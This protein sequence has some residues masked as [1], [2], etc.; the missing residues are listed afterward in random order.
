MKY[1]VEVTQIG[2]MVEQLS[3]HNMIILFNADAPKDLVEISVL[4]TVD[5]LREDVE[6]GDTMNIGNIKYKITGVG[7]AVNKNLKELGHCT[8]V[9]NGS[10]EPHLPGVINLEGEIPKIKKGD[11]ISIY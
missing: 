2:E 10:N 8:L 6:V 7:S 3:S 11:T 5:T 9:F 4:H 1:K